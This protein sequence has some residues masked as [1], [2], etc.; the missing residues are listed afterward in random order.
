MY[1]VIKIIKTGH[2]CTFFF[3][4][5]VI[6]KIVIKKNADGPAVDSARWQKLV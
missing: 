4:E 2:F 5:E 1:L 3:K 6:T